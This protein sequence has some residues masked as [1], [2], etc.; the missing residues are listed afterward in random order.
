MGGGGR[1]NRDV[2]GE[3]KREPKK[4]MVG[5]FREAGAQAESLPLDMCCGSEGVSGQQAVKNAAFLRPVNG[6]S[7][8]IR[9]SNNG[10]PCL[11]PLSPFYC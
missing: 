3:Q 2:G 7:L 1:G 8:V 4:E 10:D 6:I 5:G 11:F 9:S